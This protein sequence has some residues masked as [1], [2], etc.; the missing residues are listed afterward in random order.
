[1][2][3]LRIVAE[4]SSGKLGDAART[5]LGLEFVPAGE[6][7]LAQVQHHRQFLLRS[8]DCWRLTFAPEP[9]GGARQRHAANHGAPGQPALSD[10]LLT[11]IV[12]RV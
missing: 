8:A 12:A 2:R 3:T 10:H 7:A 1:M 11:F 4:E 6:V 9:I 5:P